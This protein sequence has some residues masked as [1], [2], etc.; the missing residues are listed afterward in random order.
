MP[1]LFDT[2]I[3]DFMSH[4]FL[5]PPKLQIATTS[6][7]MSWVGQTVKLKCQ[8]DGV[9]TPGTNLMEIK[10]SVT[11]NEITVQ[12]AVNINSNFGIFKCVAE[13]GLTP[14]DEKIVKINQIG[15]LNKSERTDGYT[16]IYIY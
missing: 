11:K 9:P 4:S 10:Y 13:N 7:L 3:C 1:P 15:R 14:P 2:I 6:S 5:N 8:S 16:M 12:V